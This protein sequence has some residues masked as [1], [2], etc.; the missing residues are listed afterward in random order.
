[1]SLALG[2]NFSKG[3]FPHI[4][5]SRVVSLLAVWKKSWYWEITVRLSSGESW[6]HF[7]CARRHPF[8][9]L[10]VKLNAILSLS[11]HKYT[12][13]TG[14]LFILLHGFDDCGPPPIIPGWNIL[15]LLTI[16][17]PDHPQPIEAAGYI[18]ITRGRSLS[19]EEGSFPAIPRIP[20]INL[21]QSI[22]EL[23]PFRNGRFTFRSYIFQRL[24]KR[25]L[26]CTAIVLLAP[27]GK[28]G[29]CSRD[30]KVPQ[31]AEIVYKSR[32]KSGLQSECVVW[33]DLGSI[34]VCFLEIFCD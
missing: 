2:W 7:M 17:S 13:W 31:G 24:S 28:Y 23:C 22:F 33:K 6:A 11:Y 20:R 26:P 1:M 3:L 14:F 25:F 12:Q 10:N 21:L 4:L 9:L 15:P 5:I 27:G 8:D 18:D 30:S 34:R 19:Q 16:I 29:I 32:G